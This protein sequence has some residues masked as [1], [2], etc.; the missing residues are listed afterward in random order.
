MHN[1]DGKSLTKSQSA[2]NLKNESDVYEH[3]L[4]TLLRV[5]F[6]NYREKCIPFKVMPRRKYEIFKRF[7]KEKTNNMRK[8]RENFLKLVNPF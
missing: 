1:Q 4:F 5:M 2:Q 3:V 8:V 6:H 7:V